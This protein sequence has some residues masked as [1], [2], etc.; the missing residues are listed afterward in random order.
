MI[1]PLED[2]VRARLPDNVE[3][4]GWISREELARLY[5]QAAGFLH[6]GDEEQSQQDK[7]GVL[8]HY[9]PEGNVQSAPLS[10]QA[11]DLV[12]KSCAI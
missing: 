5:R 6:V 11:N 12:M 9:V 7:E 1:G 8:A 3:L 2:A 4:R 10:L